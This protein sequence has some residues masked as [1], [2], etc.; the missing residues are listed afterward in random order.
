MKTAEQIRDYIYRS[1]NNNFKKTGKICAT[2]ITFSPEDCHILMKHDRLFHDFS[3]P[4]DK[5]QTFIGYKYKIGKRTKVNFKWSYE[6]KMKFYE[7]KH[8]KFYRPIHQF[9]YLMPT[10]PSILLRDTIV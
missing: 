6:R 4:V 7:K 2:S 1:I 8:G 10:G 3:S 5:N 9:G